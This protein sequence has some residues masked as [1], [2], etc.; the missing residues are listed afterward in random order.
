MSD[1]PLTGDTS[2]ARA[3]TRVLKGIVYA[4]LVALLLVLGARMLFISGE[5][6]VDESTTRPGTE[7]PVAG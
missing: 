1:R 6:N 3:E 5:K 2:T 7:A 4:A